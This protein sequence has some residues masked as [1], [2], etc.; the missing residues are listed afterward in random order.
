MSKTARARAWY[1]PPLF[2]AALLPFLALLW[3]GFDGTLGANPVETIS[4]ATG[5]W[6]LRFLC[7]TLC[8]TP[9]RRL[10]GQSW[11]LRLR[12][13]LGL[14]AFFYASLH[15]LTYFALD[16][17]FDFAQLGAE[18]IK[19]PWICVGFIAYL[20]LIPLAVTSTQAMMKRL[21][22]RWAALHR[23]IYAISILAVLHFLWL[24]KADVRE[25]LLYALILAVLFGW[26]L[27][28]RW[29]NRTP[30][31]PQATTVSRAG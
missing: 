12:R 15:V 31:R 24:V 6:A 26:R 9:L 5:D 19:R 29:L 11:P 17:E 2:L 21:G 16:L 4:H 23:A 25:P 8:C 13:M 22:R 1:K 18:V 30:A 20:L 27:R 3:R 28:E 14:Y 7:L 10:S